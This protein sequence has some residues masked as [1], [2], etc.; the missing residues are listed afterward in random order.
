MKR[1]AC[2]AAFGALGSSLCV[3][4]ASTGSVIGAT[5]RAAAL[6][7]TAKYAAHEI[8]VFYPNHP[9]LTYKLGNCKLLFRRPWVAWGCAYETGVLGPQAGAPRECVVLKLALKRLPEANYRATVAGIV[10]ITH[11][12][13][14]PPWP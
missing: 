1:A 9:G 10:R 12:P 13:R 7:A 6:A 11:S 3:S 5:P 2:V 14:C 8:Q 4:P